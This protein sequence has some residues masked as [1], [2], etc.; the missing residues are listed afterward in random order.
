METLIFDIKGDL[1]HFRKYYTTSSPLTFSFPP[2]PTVRGILGAIY[3]ASKEDYLKLFSSDQCKVATRILNPIK[4]VRMGINLINT[5]DNFWQPIK[6]GRHEARTQIRTEFVKDPAYR[7]YFYHKDSKVFEQ[8][9][10]FVKNH[11]EYYTVSLGLSELLADVSYVGIDEFS[12]FA[13]QTVDVV[14]VIPLSSVENYEV[15]LEYGK[16]YFKELIPIDMNADRVIE[17]YEDVVFETNGSSIKALMKSF[18]KGANG[19][20]V[21]FF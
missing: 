12:E 21:A 4:K 13:S 20:C 1:G 15:K 19:E 2:P 14:S 5:Q 16:K 6:K 7:I 8:M 17:R 10:D 3:G 9:V 18:W 11:K